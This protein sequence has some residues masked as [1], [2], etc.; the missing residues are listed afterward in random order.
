MHIE[1]GD[2]GRY[3]MIIISTITFQ[4]EFGSPLTLKDVMYVLGLKKNLVLVAMLEDH[5]YDMIFRK[6]KDFLCHISSGQ[7]KW[8]VVQV[9]NLYKLDVEDCANLSSKLEKV[10]SRDIGELWHKILGHL[11]HGALKITH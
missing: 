2:D 10:Q 1:M 7:L 3:S 6:G 4:R 8:I 11:H 5:S 9:K